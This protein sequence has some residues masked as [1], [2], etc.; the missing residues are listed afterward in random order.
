MSHLRRFLI[1]LV[2]VL[3]AALAALHDA[4]IA[5]AKGA[6]SDAVTGLTTANSYSPA[7]PEDNPQGLSREN[8]ALSVKTTAPASKW[9]YYSSQGK[10]VYKALDFHG[11]KIMDFSTAGYEQGAKPIPTAPV[12][13]TVSPSGGD[14]TANIQAAIATVSALTLNAKTGL[15]GAVLLEPGS[16]TVSSSLTIIASGVV[17]RGSGSGVSPSSNTVI[18]MSPA[19]MPYPLVILGTNG[20]EPS[21]IGSSTVITDAYVPAGTLTVHVASAAGLSVG[22]TV[23]I[24]RP[25]TAAWETFMGMTAS[26]LGT[27]CSGSPCNWITVG[28]DALRTDR[29]ITAIHGKQLTLDAPT[30]DSINSTYCGVDGATLQAYTFSGRITQV[31]VENLRA[32]APV[33]P[34][35]LVPPTPT[36]Q[37]VVTYS[38]LNAWVRNLSAQDTLQ[39]VNVGDYSKQVTVRNVAIKHTVTQTDDAQ[40]EEFFLQSATQ[41]LIDTV[42]DVADDTFFFAT[43]S[44]TQGPNVLRNARFEGNSSIEPHQRWATGLLIEDTKITAIPH[45]TQGNINLWDRGD[46]GTGQGWAIGWGVVWNSTANQFTIQ[47]PPGSENWCIGCIGTQVT[48]AAPGGSTVLPQGAIDSPGTYVSPSSLYQAQLKQRLAAGSTAISEGISE[49]ENF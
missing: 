10:L 41:V 19:A 4:E 34:N 23:I 36:Y 37:L 44:A 13:A 5:L 47:Q 38:V 43:S 42:S 31:G 32:L 1:A 8:S 18:T 25:V 3:F 22:T 35:D 21:Y 27:T 12:E 6:T 24:H 26:D 39:S 33:P 49:K 17:L 40:F 16:F 11:D 14:D 30:S 45:S 46:Y 20:N 29:T 48:K 2:I 7:V 9:V 28:S 15:R